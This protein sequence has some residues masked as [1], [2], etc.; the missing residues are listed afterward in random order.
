MAAKQDLKKR[1]IKIIIRGRATDNDRPTIE[2][3]VNQ[4]RDF[5]H[6]LSLVEIA[7]N[8]GLSSSEVVW[9]VTRVTMRSPL[10]LEAEGESKRHGYDVSDRVI[11]TKH[12]ALEGLAQLSKRPERPA[13]FNDSALQLANQLF[14]RV[15]NG[16]SQTD[17]VDPLKPRRATKIRADAALGARRNLDIILRPVEPL[18]E[19]MEPT[20][21]VELG[22]VEGTLA[23]TGRW[24]GKPAFYVRDAL[25]GSD[26]LCFP[27]RNLASRFGEETSVSE[28]WRGKRVR[29]SGI[30]E[31]TSA[32]QV[33][34]IRADSV[35][36]LSER[37]KTPDVEE[38]FDPDFTGGLSP[39]AY[40]ER[41]RGE[42]A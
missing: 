18:T 34:C 22:S 32:G 35:E 41:L 17:V 24:R 39:L 1:R 14:D 26:V 19:V 15:S 42:E 21:Y 16:L 8:P 10:T 5:F 28:V 9:R 27:G 3:V 30:I 36:E 37:N 29:V 11:R 4:V 38:I 31:Y 2:D 40:L 23:K 12:L 6:L 33:K 7:A 20:Q 13:H 25:T